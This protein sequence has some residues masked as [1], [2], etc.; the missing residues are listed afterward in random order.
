MLNR[1]AFVAICFAVGLLISLPFVVSNRIA[2]ASE[3][4]EI[5]F[6]ITS[7]NIWDKEKIDNTLFFEKAIIKY[8]KLNPQIRIK[9]I[10][11]LPRREYS[12]W[13]AQSILKGNQPDIFS[14]LPEDFCTLA[15]IGALEALDKHIEKLKPNK[16]ED[17]ISKVL[18]TGQYK[19]IQYA[20][21]FEVIPTIMLV[22]ESML[23]GEGIDLPVKDWDW[24]D[25]VCISNS[26]I[27]DID[28]DGQQDQYGIT[29][30]NWQHA[31]YSLEKRLFDEDGGKVF[32]NDSDV[33]Y[34]VKYATSLNQ[35]NMNLTGMDFN[36]GKV[37]FRPYPFSAARRMMKNDE[38][39]KNS[40]SFDWKI[41]KIPKGLDGKTSSELHS[42]P[43]AISARSQYKSEAWKFI[44]F[45]SGDV[46][47]QKD[48]LKYSYGLP[49]LKSVL[50]SDETTELLSPYAD[51]GLLHEA[52]KESIAPFTFRKYK[53]AMNMADKEIFQF[54]KGDKDIDVE[55]EKLN[56]EISKFLHE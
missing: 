53:Q 46:E 49:I 27:K 42:M 26:V 7:D 56:N 3:P 30:Y 16:L 20:M 52:I 32:L 29:G 4:I 38:G 47:I 13:L 24:F 8:E 22:N 45:I 50:M 36:S 44:D 33:V 17:V 40:A 35:R 23:N 6:S 19:G 9:L 18:K 14:V 21:P 2:N 1:K 31:V 41:I 25:L 54:I 37:A 51:A 28:G 48:V 43:V 55:L 12:E 39:I 5:L 15:S 34:M 10:K 11:G